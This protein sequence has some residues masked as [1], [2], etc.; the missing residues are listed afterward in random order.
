MSIW[1][2]SFIPNL[3]LGIESFAPFTLWVD[4][5]FLQLLHQPP[6]NG[7]ASA[8]SHGKL[9]AMNSASAPL[10]HSSWGPYVNAD[11]VL[12]SP[13]HSNAQ[14]CARH[15]QPMGVSVWQFPD[16]HLRGRGTASHLAQNL[17]MFITRCTSRHTSISLFRRVINSPLLS[18]ESRVRRLG[19]ALT[20]TK[21]STP[22]RIPWVSM[23]TSLWSIFLLRFEGL[24]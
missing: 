3:D 17:M 14:M 22:C 23:D 15:P 13:F 8:P 24:V 10:F 6:W 1:P 18:A 12:G 19:R 11:H 21:S 4:F 5:L 16:W 7:S 9:G 20:V 2:Q